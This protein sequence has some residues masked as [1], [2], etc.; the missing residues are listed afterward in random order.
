ME[1]FE[2]TAADENPPRRRTNQN[3]PRPLPA[4]P[5]LRPYQ[6]EAQQAILEHRARGVRSQIVSLATGLGKCVDPQTWVWSSGLRRF[7]DAWGNDRIAG[8]HKTDTV[9]AWYDDGVNP[10]RRVTTQAGLHIDGTLAHRL[11]IR[12]DDGFEGWCCMEDIIVGDYVAIGRGHADFGTKQVP[13]HQAY[14]LGLAI[15]DGADGSLEVAAPA[16]LSSRAESRD[17]SNVGARGGPSTSLGMTTHLRDGAAAACVSET[18]VP[19]TILHGDRA[20][21]QAFLRGYFDGCGVAKPIAGCSASSLVLAEQVQQLLLGLGVFCGIWTHTPTIGQPAQMVCIYDLEAFEIQVGFTR[22]GP[23]QDRCG[24]G[25]L[26]HQRN[27]NYDVIPGVGALIRELAQQIPA[28][29]LSNDFRTM[30][31]YYDRTGWRRPSY[32]LLRRW[33]AVAPSCA[34]ADEL[35]RIAD[36]HRAWTP[37]TQIEPSTMR[38]ID[39]QV[40]DSHAFIGNGLVNHNTV[41]LATLPKLLSLRPGDVTLVVAHR[42]ELIEQTVEKMRVENPDAKIGV[43]KAERKAPEDSNIVVATVQT[44]SEKRL[45]S[46]VQ[47]FHR[48]ISLFII[49]EAHHAAAPSYRAI[50]DAILAQRPEAMVLGFTATPN[51]G[52]GVRLVDVFE[53]IVYS[54]D[55]RKAID[56]GYLVPVKSYAVATTTNLD[57]IASRGGDFVIGQLA[58]AVNTVDRN[59]R[60]VAA[61]KQHTPG[62]KALVFTASV[63]H[64]R[65]VAEEFVAKDVKAEWA[66]GETPKDEREKIVRDFRNGDLDVLVNCGL[67]LEGFD[68]PSVQVILNARPTKSTTLYTQITGRALRPV[69]EIANLLS[70]TESALMRRE[71][72]EKSTKP[73][74]LIIDF[75]DQAQRHQL[76]T[77]PSLYG[78]PPQ[79]DAQGRMTAQVAEKFEELLRR[80]PKRAA[81]VRSA[82]EIETALLEIDGF[83]AP[84]EIKPTWAPLDPDH[85]R[86]LLPPQRIAWD[87]SGRPIPNFGQQWDQWVTEARRIAPHEDADRFASR[88]LNVNPK[89]VKFDSPRIDVQR[90]GDEYLTLYTTDDV[91]DRVIDRNKSLP[92]ALGNA[93]ERVKEI[94]SGYTQI[95]GPPPRPKAPGTNG[96]RPPNGGAAPH[97]NAAPRRKRDRRARAQRRKP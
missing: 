35:R 39:A 84:K 54:M 28:K 49:D 38:R 9:V 90:D 3:G 5:R 24:S 75:V 62:M 41:V 89:T 71:L 58:A 30:S 22:P 57:D 21:V 65:D 53:K 11:W 64:A 2:A 13:V 88:M 20:A 12:R 32:H 18:V 77:L 34:A 44:L 25:A 72:V 67:Y 46:F 87:K 16:P 81:K 50:V 61:Y 97:D 6:V 26:H 55:A 82:E 27:P 79:I 19:D 86:M 14:L 29:Y 45:E 59:A 56:A 43:E 36:E 73:A 15:A 40:E 95:G 85:W 80:D 83:A 8:P 4:A 76:V 42:D 51:R 23:V 68:V 31:A 52:D 17:S 66:S 10:G 48:R 63:E 70:S 47:R 33:L 78:L 96:H 69:D 1:Q 93:Y 60:I 37:V 92:G 91:P 74:A 7:E 94:L